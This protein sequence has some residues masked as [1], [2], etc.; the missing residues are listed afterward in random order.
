M[1]A[2]VVRLVTEADSAAAARFA[3]CSSIART[4]FLY[5]AQNASRRLI[6]FS[7]ILVIVACQSRFSRS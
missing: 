7:M 2:A 3:T 1:V 6:G 4:T 5:G